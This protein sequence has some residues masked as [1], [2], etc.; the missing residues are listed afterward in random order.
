M[1]KEDHKVRKNYT[2]IIKKNKNHWKA[3]GLILFFRWLFLK[4]N[5]VI[6]LVQ[7]LAVV[8]IISIVVSVL[9]II[10]II[11]IC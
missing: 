8:I 11:I 6:Q 10:I 9:K 2:I 7:I 3:F 1:E 5:S 4:W